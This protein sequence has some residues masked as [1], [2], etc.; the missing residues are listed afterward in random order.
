MTENANCAQR[1]TIRVFTQAH[2]KYNFILRY[3]TNLAPRR[4]HLGV[5]K[6]MKIIAAYRGHGGEPHAFMTTTLN[7]VVSGR[8][9]TRSRSGKKKYS[10]RWLRYP[11]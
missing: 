1:L 7:V 10:G 8:H 6:H 3:D 11:E 9:M 5:M 4:K 2:R